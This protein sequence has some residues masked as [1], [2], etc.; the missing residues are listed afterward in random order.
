MKSDVVRDYTK[1][2]STAYGPLTR[3]GYFPDKLTDKYLVKSRFLDTYTGLLELESTLPSNALK[4]RLPAPKRIT[5]TKD[6]YLK[7][8]FRRERDLNNIFKVSISFDLSK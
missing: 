3:D 5:S 4:I 1:Y 7:R 6:G 8:Q 2:E